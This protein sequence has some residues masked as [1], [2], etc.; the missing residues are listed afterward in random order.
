MGWEIKGHSSNRVTLMTPEPNGGFYGERGVKDFVERY[1]HDV[2]DGG[3][4]FTGG[5]KVGVPCVATGMTLRVSGFDPANP[6]LFDVSGAV[7]LVRGQA[8]PSPINLVWI[9]H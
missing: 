5:H 7:Q 6:K 1:G 4:Y 8:R 2:K 9:S 3:M